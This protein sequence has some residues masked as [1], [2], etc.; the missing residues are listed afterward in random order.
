MA[1]EKQPVR[2]RFSW[3]Y[4]FSFILIVGI[5][6]TVIVLLFNRN[7]A[8]QFTE[9]EFVNALGNDNITEIY[10]KSALLNERLVASVETPLW[11]KKTDRPVYFGSWRTVQLVTFI[12]NSGYWKQHDDLTMKQ[13][14]LIAK[15]LDGDKSVV[16]QIKEL[17]KEIDALRESFYCTDPEVAKPIR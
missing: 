11:D 4:L 13:S 3:S 7:T 12:F 10:V 6:V 2:R 14:E 8:T 9:Q 17:A 1:D 5:I 15:F 16:P